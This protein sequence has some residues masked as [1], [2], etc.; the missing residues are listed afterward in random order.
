MI[1]RE[2]HV[3]DIPQIQYVRNSVHENTLSNPNL[4]TDK[5][6]EEYILNR[7]KAWVC[8]I[9]DRI[10]GF[11][12]VDLKE[13]N[14]WAL[15][16][17]PDFDKKGIGRGLHDTMLNWYFEQTEKNLRLETE[18]NTRADTFY[19]KSGWHEIG[20]DNNGEIQFEMTKIRWENRKKD[21]KN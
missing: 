13:Q 21:S 1:I 5:D 2:A 8:E 4:V 12:M 6:C 19:R 18:P 7:G 11:A 15:F 9:D 16:V 20:K 14:V 3:N 10:V 17:H